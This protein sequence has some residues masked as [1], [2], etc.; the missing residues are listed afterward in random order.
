MMMK[1]KM[2]TMMM[3]M[4]VRQVVMCSHWKPGC[5]DSHC[6]VTNIPQT[7]CASVIIIVIVVVIIVVV[8]VVVFTVFSCFIVIITIF[9][10]LFIRT[11]LIFIIV[12]LQPNRQHSMPFVWR[13]TG[14]SFL[15]DGAILQFCQYGNKQN[16]NNR[17]RYSFLFLNFYFYTKHLWLK[18]GTHVRETRSLLVPDI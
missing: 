15:R 1:M 16:I 2:S 5:G 3:I 10:K 7:L 14:L 12:P 8:V 6:S 4:R 17:L 11:K 13:K 18:K 9:K